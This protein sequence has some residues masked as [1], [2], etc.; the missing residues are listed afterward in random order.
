M[1]D[2]LAAHPPDSKINSHQKNFEK[3]FM[4]PPSRLAN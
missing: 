1:T 3:Q 4:P 2:V